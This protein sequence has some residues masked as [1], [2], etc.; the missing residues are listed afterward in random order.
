HVI[1][2]YTAG[3]REA[4]KLGA[5]LLARERGQQVPGQFASDVKESFEKE[6]SYEVVKKFILDEKPGCEFEGNSLWD[7][8][9][10][11]GS[12]DMSVKF[13]LNLPVIGV[14]APA[15]VFLP[16]VAEWLGTDFT[17]VE[18]YE[19]GNAVGA[20]T[21]RVSRRIDVLVVEKP[22]T[23]GFLIFLPDDRRTI[24]VEDEEKAMEEAVNL[25]KNSARKL[26]RQSG[27]E[28]ISLHVR[29]EP[30]THGRGK[31]HVTAIGSPRLD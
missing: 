20:V 22:E 30:F 18:N 14:G 27:G 15:G 2:E 19:V 28:D 29:K 23:E 12:K 16:R 11:R 26:V 17:R 4:P 3:N 5:D 8:C 1:G 21:G 9:K 31:V 7:Y 10:K 25:G 13:E 24:E 6:I